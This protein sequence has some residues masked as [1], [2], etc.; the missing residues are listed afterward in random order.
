MIGW[1]KGIHLHMHDKQHI[2]V[3]YVDTTLFTLSREEELIRNLVSLLQ[4]FCI[5]LKLN[6]NWMKSCRY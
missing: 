6:I 3:Q 2:M 5:A 4:K 1:N